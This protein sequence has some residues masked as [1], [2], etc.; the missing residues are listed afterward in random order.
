MSSLGPSLL[1]SV[2]MLRPGLL[3]SV[4]TRLQWKTREQPLKPLEDREVLPHCDVN[5]A[6]VDVHHIQETLVA[7]WRREGRQAAPLLI[8]TQHK[9]G[10]AAGR[11]SSGAEAL[12]A[13]VGGQ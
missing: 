3:S 5:G 8:T 4:A 6:E 2:A 12:T 11:A 13:A 10:R 9:S 7:G 1:P